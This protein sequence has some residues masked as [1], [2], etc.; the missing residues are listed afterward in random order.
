VAGAAWTVVVVGGL[1]VIAPVSGAIWASAYRSDGG[2]QL[3][4]AVLGLM[5]A[6]T[7]FVV[8]KMINTDR[9]L[10]AT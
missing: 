7:A 3:I 4:T 1:S 8:L 2:D 6:T 10:T 5:S 9:E